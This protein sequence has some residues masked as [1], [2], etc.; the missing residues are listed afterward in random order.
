MG[1]LCGTNQG[2]I[3]NCYSTC[4]VSGYALIGGLCGYNYSGS[5]D[6]SFSTGNVSGNLNLGGLCGYNLAVITNSFWDTETQISGVS[7]GVGYNN[8]TITNLYFPK[9]LLLSNEL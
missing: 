2:T 5:I 3:L 7:V 6:N 4:D 9:K 8:G 1:G